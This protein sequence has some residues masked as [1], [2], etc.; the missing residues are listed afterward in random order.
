MH[1]QFRKNHKMACGQ[2][3]VHDEIIET[4]ETEKCLEDFVCN[5]GKIDKTIEDRLCHDVTN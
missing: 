3:K 1:I 2:L 4:P 5:S